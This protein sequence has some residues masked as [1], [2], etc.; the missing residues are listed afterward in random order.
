MA[1]LAASG[2]GPDVIGAGLD[3]LVAAGVLPGLW[4]NQADL[5]AGLGVDLAA[6]RRAA[7]ESF[8]VEAVSAASCRARRR[9]WRRDAPIVS[10][11]PVNPLSGKALVAKRALELSRR[12]AVGLGQQDIGAEHMLLGVLRDGQDPLAPG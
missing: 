6:V 3:Q 4:R 12:E 2:L 9:S 1:I 7:E 11:G 10:V 8:G 5:L